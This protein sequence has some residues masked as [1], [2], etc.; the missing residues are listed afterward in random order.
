MNDR[1]P[2]PKQTSPLAE[3]ITSGLLFVCFAALGWLTLWQGG[4]AVKGK[5]GLVTFV[6]GRPGRVVAALC[7]CAAAIG[8][9]MLLRSFKPGR[10]VNLIAL[11]VLMVP[12]LLYGM[13]RH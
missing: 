9:L 3:R 11:L 10:L 13:A 8:L 7:F 1:I 5:S 6:D 2:A 4:M 12:P